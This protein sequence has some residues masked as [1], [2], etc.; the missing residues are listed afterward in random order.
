LSADKILTA[1]GEPMRRRLLETL[2]VSSPMT[3]TQLAKEFPISRQ[4]ILK[5]LD[6][7]EDAGLVSV[8]R[9]GRDKRYILKTEPLTEVEQWL[10]DVSEQWDQR[11]WRLKELVED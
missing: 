9:K 7:L 8:N 4:G 1:L 3:A 6:V 5:H 2:A 10:H 11:L